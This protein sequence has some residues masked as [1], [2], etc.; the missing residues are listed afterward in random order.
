VR[1]GVKKNSTPN[2]RGGLSSQ[3]PESGV[4]WGKKMGTLGQG[5]GG[6]FTGQRRREFGLSSE[7]HSPDRGRSKEKNKKG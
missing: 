5:R 1:L 7:I 3:K 2:S 6:G 4:T